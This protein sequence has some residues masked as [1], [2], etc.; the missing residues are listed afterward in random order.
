MTSLSY[1]GWPARHGS[2]IENRKRYNHLNRVT[3]R[4]QESLRQAR[5]ALRRGER[6]DLASLTPAGFNWWGREGG[7]GVLS[8]G[9]PPLSIPA[10]PAPSPLTRWRGA[11]RLRAAQPPCS[12]DEWACT[13]Y[14]VA[15]APTSPSRAWLF[16]LYPSITVFF[17]S[18]S[19]SLPPF[20]PVFYLVQVQLL[21]FFFI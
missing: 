17:S 3:E 15:V 10:S 9:T 1:H 7:S 4:R 11:G 8:P 2:E 20:S 16:P 19:T 6:T 14:T 5:L 13:M 18:A 12:R 21:P